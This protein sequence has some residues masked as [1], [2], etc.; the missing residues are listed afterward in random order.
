MPLNKFSP[1]ITKLLFG[2]VMALETT[3][4]D[5]IDEKVRLSAAGEMVAGK[6]QKT[7]QMRKNVSMDTWIMENQ[8]HIPYFLLNLV[9]KYG[10][11]PYIYI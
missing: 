11:C 10:M 3:F 2:N 4:G 7:P 9:E 8:E 6:W 5:V 1:P